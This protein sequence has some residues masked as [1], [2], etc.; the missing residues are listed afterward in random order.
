MSTVDIFVTDVGGAQRN[1][2]TVPGNAP[3]VKILAAL[4]DSLNLPL[5]GPDGQPMSYK[6]H[7]N[8]SGKQIKD[9]ATLEQAGVENGHTLRL[10][11]EIVAG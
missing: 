1:E 4:V 9:D 2:V 7:H 11:P 8:E 6:F 5:T 10:I 3:A